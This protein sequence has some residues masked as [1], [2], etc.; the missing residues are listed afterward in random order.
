MP[1][2]TPMPMP[3]MQPVPMPV[4][5]P[6]Y[7]VPVYGAYGQP[8]VAPPPGAP[9]TPP[10]PPSTSGSYPALSRSGPI[11]PP[12]VHEVDLGSDLDEPPGKR[13]R[14]WLVVLGTAVLA[15]GAA[16][17]YFMLFAVPPPP[18]PPPPPKTEAPVVEV[19]PPEP[20][21]APVPAPE[22]V[23]EPPKPP[24]AP[25]KPLP[26]TT[27]QLLAK[28]RALLEKGDS[29]TALDI[30]GR[31]ASKDPSNVEALTGRGLCYLDLENFAPAEAS[32][33]A[34]LRIEPD[35][36]DAML[37]LAESYRFEGKKTEAIAQYEKYLARHPDGDDVE[38]AKNALEQ[39]RK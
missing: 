12:P 23:V 32:F 16:A 24:P 17:V 26:P 28:A 22:P 30:F 25:E 19:K 20:P 13:A 36:P 8:A 3:A 38:V 2:V 21:P 27:K 31:I 39:L 10:P 34:A 4:P 5:M 14:T 35:Q 29:E 15:G 11:L 6:V 37:G 1:A 7:G 9:P 18:P 33:E